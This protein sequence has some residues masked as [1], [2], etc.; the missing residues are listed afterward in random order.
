V[1]KAATAKVLLKSMMMNVACC[2]LAG[3]KNRR[4]DRETS[5][6][7]NT[8]STPEKQNDKMRAS[9]MWRWEKNFIGR[10]SLLSTSDTE[11]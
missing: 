5:A 6:D 1:T 8:V 10:L 4:S 9:V 7:G 11:P 3:L 2:I